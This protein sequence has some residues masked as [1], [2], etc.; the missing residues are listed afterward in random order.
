[1]AFD[2]LN[3]FSNY[4][5]IPDTSSY[6]IDKTAVSLAETQKML[7]AAIRSLLPGQS[8]QGEIVS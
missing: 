3:M 7:Q 8:L 4:K 6:S 5:P 1:M 2:L